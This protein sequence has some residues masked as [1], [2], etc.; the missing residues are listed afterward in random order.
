MVI[1]PPGPSTPLLVV[2][3]SSGWWVDH[4]APRLADVPI[5][6]ELMAGWG[7]ADGEPPA[8]GLFVLGENLTIG[9]ESL[10]RFARLRP[11]PCILAL[12][13]LRLPGLPGLARELGATRI[14]SG[15]VPPPLVA[16][17]FRDWAALRRRRIPQQAGAAMRPTPLPH[18]TML[19]HQP[20][21]DGAGN[22]HG[23][24]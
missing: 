24:A 9:L 1:V 20:G 13:P 14:I 19:T 5:R 23:R 8:F 21:P 16:T 2:R 12:D 10:D 11:C 17:I 18:P 15:P 4:L 6:V 22:F 7:D 3:D